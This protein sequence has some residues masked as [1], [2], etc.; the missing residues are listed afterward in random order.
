M[1]AVLRDYRTAPIPEAE[2]ELFAFIEKVT[3]ACS[4]IEQ[5]DIDRLHQAGWSDAG[6]LDAVLV[7]ALF[8][9][10]NRLVDATGVVPLSDKGHA[11]SGR[12]IAREGYRMP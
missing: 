4:E 9:F 2:K 10:Y 3:L 5:A 7:C 6:I 8:H 11:Q 12:R 1:D